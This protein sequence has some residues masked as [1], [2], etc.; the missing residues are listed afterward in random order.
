MTAQTQHRAASGS[1]PSHSANSPVQHRVPAWLRPVASI[2][3]R[4]PLKLR[5]RQLVRD[6]LYATGAMRA[7]A[8]ASRFRGAIILMYHSVASEGQAAWIDPSNHLSPEV[9]EHQV[10][11]LSRHREIVTLSELIQTIRAGKS[12]K[13][14]TAVITFD[15]GY[16][17]NLQIAAPLLR[18]FGLPATL[19]LPTG[20]ISRGQNH[21]IDD[22]YTIFRYR[23]R[24]HLRLQEAHGMSV[25]LEPKNTHEVYRRLCSILIRMTYADRSELLAQLSE[26]LQPG[27]LP[28]RLTMNWHDVRVL[29]KNYPEF[30]LGGHTVDHLDVSQL[31]GSQL[32]EELSACR[33]SIIHET[34]MEPLHFSFPYGRFTTEARAQANDSGFISACGGTGDPLVKANTDPMALRRV[35]APLCPER[36][37]FL[38][39][40]GNTRFFA[41]IAD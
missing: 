27:C 30:E 12:P 24:N 22:L 15:D 10:R 25:D 14:N 32:R 18:R 5:A 4:G 31:T 34:G 33:R 39:S 29:V 40:S 1:P 28:P 17:D 35:P 16:L 19:F 41:K 8:R 21:W 6:G 11:F 26:R 9:F 36:L 20:Y 13:R 2:M 7:L 38:S 3:P 37:D 23:Q